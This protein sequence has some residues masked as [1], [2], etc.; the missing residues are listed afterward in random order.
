M[1]LIAIGDAILNLDRITVLD[2][3]RTSPTSAVVRVHGD[4]AQSIIEIG[5][6]LPVAAAL[7]ELVPQNLRLAGADAANT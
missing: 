3:D 7:I 2:I 4:S 5:V 1:Q 6:S